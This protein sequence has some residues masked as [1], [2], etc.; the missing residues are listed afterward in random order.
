MSKSFRRVS[1]IK[2]REVLSTVERICVVANQ[3][4]TNKVLNDIYMI[5]HPFVGSC[6][7][8]HWDWRKRQELLKKELDEQK[9]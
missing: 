8:P 4:E 7:N 6:G 2:L 5:V 9:I 3:D 1:P